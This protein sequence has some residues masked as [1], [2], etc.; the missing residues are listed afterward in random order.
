LDYILP[1]HNEETML[2]TSFHTIIQP[3]MVK[4]QLIF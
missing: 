4:L 3:N 1:P 2:L